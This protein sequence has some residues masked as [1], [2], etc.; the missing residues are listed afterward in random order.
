MGEAVTVSTI[1]AQGSYRVQTIRLC[2]RLW[3]VVLFFFWGVFFVE[4]LGEWFVRAAEWP[5]R[6][7]AALQGLHLLFLLGLAIGLRWELAGGLL[8]LFAAVAFFSQAAGSNAAMF[9]LV[10]VVPAVVWI[11]LAINEHRRFSAT[12]VSVGKAR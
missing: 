1:H 11:G 10:S 5:P 4:H 6:R 7:V 9:T 3:A 2:T 8:S 12:G